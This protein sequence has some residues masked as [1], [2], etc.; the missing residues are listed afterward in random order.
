MAYLDR[1]LEVEDTS[2]DKA[3]DKGSSHLNDEGVSRVKFGVVGEFE[4]I[5]EGHSL[6]DRDVSVGLEPDKSVGV[7]LD[8][9]ASNELGN[10]VKSDLNTS[11]R[12]N[13]SEKSA[14]S[15]VFDL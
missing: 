5:D 13:Q 6:V 15:W 14:K 7:T 3:E 12:L 4:V 9:G 8:E 11:D 10:D 2:R 1:H